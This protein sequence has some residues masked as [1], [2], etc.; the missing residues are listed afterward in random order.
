MNERTRKFGFGEGIFTTAN[1]GVTGAIEHAVYTAN[2]TAV[3]KGI[4]A[5]LFT[6]AAIGI[7]YAVKDVSPEEIAERRRQKQEKKH[8]RS[9]RDAIPAL[10]SG[11]ATLTSF[12]AAYKYGAHIPTEVFSAYGPTADAAAIGLGFANR[13]RRTSPATLRN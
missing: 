2:N 12:A 5:A 3:N 10:L 9:V 1:I 6:V 8:R 4:F 7:Y 11:V 13:V